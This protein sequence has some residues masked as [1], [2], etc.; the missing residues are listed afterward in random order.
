MG[1]YV[2]TQSKQ[3]VE[4]E[5]ADFLPLPFGGREKG[6]FFLLPV[7]QSTHL[8]HFVHVHILKMIALL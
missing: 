5:G 2:S 4:E 1:Y 7:T 8:N 3:G 6:F